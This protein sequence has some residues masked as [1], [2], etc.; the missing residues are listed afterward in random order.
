MNT[1][2]FTILL[3]ITILL[4]FSVVSRIFFNDFQDGWNAYNKNDYKTARELWLPIAEQGE[5]RAQFFMGFMHDMGFGVPE[6]DK[7]AIKWYQLA[8]EQGDARAQ[9][10][11]GFLY[12]FGIGIPGNDKSALKWYQLAAAQGYTEAD[13]NIFELE[14]KVSPQVF[15]NFLD[16]ANNGDPKSQYT[17]S[18][19]YA[20]GIGVPKNHKEARKW[21]SLARRQGYVAKINIIELTKTND[22]Q[23]LITEAEGRKGSAEAQINLAIMY[24]FGLVVSQ[25]HEKALK[26]YK[27]AAKQGYRA[28]ENVLKIVRLN[29]PEEVKKII[30]NANK[31]IAKSQYT[32]GMMYAEGQGVPQDKN[33]AL[34]WYGYAAQQD[35]QIDEIVVDKFE[36]KN[37]PQE[38]KFLTNNAENGIAEAQLK[39]GMLYAHGQGVPQD[40]GR[41]SKWLRLAGE[42]GKFK[43]QYILGMMLADGQGITKDYVLAHMWYNLSGLQ[44]NLG[45]TRQMSALEKSMSMEQ[46]EQAQK[47]VREWQPSK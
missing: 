38:L 7:E 14:S 30:F 32:L 39:L 29:N 40:D 34:K 46:I 8:A 11:T 37:I 27:L 1:K 10:F 28:A 41:A 25:D 5:V 20:K 16:D 21:F 47:M 3:V 44:G 2:K 17:L 12:D 24:E 33:K 42:Q 23:D 43:A 36:N 4:I 15:L 45:A 6:N 26:F 9:L 22:L 18:V 19:M 31:G 35:A 13:L